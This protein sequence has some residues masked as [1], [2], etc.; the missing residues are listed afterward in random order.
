MKKSIFL[1][2]LILALLLTG[3]SH[4]KPG[5]DH[6]AFYYQAQNMK[7]DPDD[8]PFQAEYHHQDEFSTLDEALAAYFIGPDSTEL[9][10]PFPA[11]LTLISYRESNG[12]LYLVLSDQFA[13]LTG[14]D[15]TI[16]CCCIAK[17][18][19]GMTEAHTV[20]ISAENSLLDG[21]K[22]IVL[23]DKTMNLLD[24]SQH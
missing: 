2:L 12:V 8:S 3:C 9:I 1:M 11:G 14:K 16:A 17:T 24:D 22:N 13:R 5:D 10:D 19:L 15:L 21:E 6:F 20:S 23:N 4:A 7:Y 18:C